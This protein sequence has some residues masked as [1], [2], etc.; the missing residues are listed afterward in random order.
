M[1][2]ATRSNSAI[3][4]KQS[5]CLHTHLDNGTRSEQLTPELTAD[6][7]VAVSTSLPVVHNAHPALSHRL[8][9]IQFI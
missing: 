4:T 9:K 6:L 3:V 8:R 7:A 2:L 1:D 5:R